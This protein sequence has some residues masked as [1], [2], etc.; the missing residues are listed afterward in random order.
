MDDNGFFSLLEMSSEDSLTSNRD[1]ELEEKF[2]MRKKN[3]KSLMFEKNAFENELNNKLPPSLPPKPKINNLKPKKFAMAN[4]IPTTSPEVALFRPK[5]KTSLLEFSSQEKTPLSRRSGSTPIPP[6]NPPNN[7][8][9]IKKSPK[10]KNLN[11]SINSSSNLKKDSPKKQ[12][13]IKKKL[14]KVSNLKSLFFF[15]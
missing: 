5:Y 13:K 15:F 2:K 1:K 10:H 11:N 8:N 6:D 14:F 9:K 12:M 3:S 7:L 4:N